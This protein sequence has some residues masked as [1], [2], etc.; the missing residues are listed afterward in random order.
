MARTRWRSGESTRPPLMW[1]GFKSR[2]RRHM[3]VE[4]VVGSLFCSERFF[5]R[6]SSFPLSSKTN[7]SKCKFQRVTQNLRVLAYIARRYNSLLS[8]VASLATWY[9]QQL[10]LVCERVTCVNQ[11]RY[12]NRVP[13][14]EKWHIKGLGVGPPGRA[15]PY[16]TLLSI[17]P[18]PWA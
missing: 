18:P 9:V 8:S 3:W 14:C 4:F 17:P 6:Y 13:F 15:S 5:S 12:T 10:L 2:R 1:P 7:I 16:K 11:R